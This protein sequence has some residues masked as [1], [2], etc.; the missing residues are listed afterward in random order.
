MLLQYMIIVRAPRF[1]VA[2]LAPTQA[3]QLEELELA[4]V[5]VLREK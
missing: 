2:E 1:R 3:A 4:P 5:A